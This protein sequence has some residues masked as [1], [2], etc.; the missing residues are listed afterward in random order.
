MSLAL[1]LFKPCV[2]R[3]RRQYHWRAL[4]VV[5]GALTGLGAPR[6]PPCHGPCGDRALA[7]PMFRRLAAPRGA[8]AARNRTLS[9]LPLRSRTA[10]TEYESQ[11][12][13]GQLSLPHCS[14]Q[15]RC[16]R[17]RCLIP[18]TFNPAVPCAWRGW[19]VL[20]CLP[21]PPHR[22][23]CLEHCPQMS[24][25]RLATFPPPNL[26]ACSAFFCCFRELTL[27]RPT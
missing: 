23:N 26:R 18:R 11:R 5:V 25:G 2:D 8:I 14:W 9:L 10:P 19:S 22:L 12:C 4:T 17:P 21:K 16:S 1:P 7:A 3:G 15:P 20:R 6:P 13:P 24:L 27:S